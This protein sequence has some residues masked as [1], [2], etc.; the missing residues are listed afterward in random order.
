MKNEGMNRNVI[1]WIACAIWFVAGIINGFIGSYYIGVALVIISVGYVIVKVVN[2]FE[3][4]EAKE[5]MEEGCGEYYYL[6]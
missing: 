3:A 5:L 1:E 4:V 2:W 6:K